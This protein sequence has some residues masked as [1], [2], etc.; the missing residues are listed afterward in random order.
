M[1]GPEFFIGFGI[2]FLISGGIIA[3]QQVSDKLQGP[4]KRFGTS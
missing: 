2:G 3:F 1:F 4:W